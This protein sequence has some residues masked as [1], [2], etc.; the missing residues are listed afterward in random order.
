MNL[1]TTT[2]NNL[3]NADNEFGIETSEVTDDKGKTVTD[4]DG[5][6]VTKEVPVVYKRDKKGKVYAQVIDEDGKEV[7]EKGGKPVTV[8]SD[9]VEEQN[10]PSSTSTTK[11]Q[12]K[13]GK[14]ENTEKPTVTTATTTKKQETTNGNLT[15]TKPAPPTA[16]TEKKVELTSEQDTTKFT[17]KEEVPKTSAKGEEVNFSVQDQEII[18][19][20]LEVPYL[21]KHSY[22]N[23]DGVP[24][25]IAAHTAVWMAERDGGTSSKYPSGPVVLNLFKFYGQTVVNF[26][27]K[28]NE[29]AENTGAPIKYNKKDDTFTITE[30]TKKKQ[31]VRITK[32]EDLGNNNFYKITAS[33]SKADG[34]NKVVAI[35]QKN[36]LDLSLGF[37]I[38]ALK[39]S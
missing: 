20:M 6:A 24:I 38:K 14:T 18:A 29:A 25:E 30:F 1:V 4:K 39:W 23:S 5:K 3:E 19:S 33:V 2:E 11:K 12:N 21:Y 16:T 17:G 34:I 8:P 9:Y 7:T 27:S 26:K 28:C 22:E 13:P 37:S 35:V 36:K 15:T 32:I 10:N 31:D